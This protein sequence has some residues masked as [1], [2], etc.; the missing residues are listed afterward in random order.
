MIVIIAILVVISIW[1]YLIMSCHKN[2]STESTDSWFFDPRSLT[3]NARNCRSGWVMSRTDN[4]IQE[5]VKSPSVRGVENMLVPACAA[6]VPSPLRTMQR[7]RLVKE[8]PTV[9]PA[10]SS[11]FVKVHL[12]NADS[13]MDETGGVAACSKTLSQMW[14][15]D[16]KKRITNEK[17]GECLDWTTGDNNT[18]LASKKCSEATSQKWDLSPGQLTT[19]AGK[20]IDVRG[21]TSTVYDCYGGDTESWST[22]ATF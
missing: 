22:S 17:T 8:S 3:C 12:K 10:S 15:Y 20:C 18:T 1:V 13:C 6:S 2:P 5:C 7:A 19:A 9:R 21:G 16:Y 14:T 11:A 4:G